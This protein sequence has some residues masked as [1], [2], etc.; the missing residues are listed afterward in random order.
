MESC[1]HVGHRTHNA[2][3]RLRF[4]HRLHDLEQ[5]ER[6]GYVSGVGMPYSNIAMGIVSCMIDVSC[7]AT[8]MAS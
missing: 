1:R 3:T 8:Y 7:G 5:V 2:E 4:Q 6:L